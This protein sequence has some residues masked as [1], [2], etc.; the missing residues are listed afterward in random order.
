MRSPCWSLALTPR[1][2]IERWFNASP[3]RLY[4]AG[5]I[6][7][8]SRSIPIIAPI[9]AQAI[10]Q[11]QLRRSLHVSLETTLTKYQA[12]QPLI[13]V[14]A[15]ALVTP[16]KLPSVNDSHSESC[17][18]MKFTKKPTGKQLLETLTELQDLFGELRIAF[19]DRNPNR[20]SEV[21]ALI[22]RGFDLCDYARAFD[23]PEEPPEE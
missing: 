10:W 20:E 8:N 22:E 2:L 21:N 17:S 23:P 1:E 9:V 3:V 4:S 5:L 18:L 11:L 19:T 12:F 16:R 6:V 7:Q 15:I 14:E 13:L